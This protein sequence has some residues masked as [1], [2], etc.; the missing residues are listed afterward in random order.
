MVLSE[1]RD[2]IKV[3][4]KEAD[5]KTFVLSRGDNEC[6]GLSLKVLDAQFHPFAENCIVSCG[7]KHI[8]FWNLCGN[9]LT[10]KKGIFGKVRNSFT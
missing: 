9:A 10:D 2:T 6:H 4:W 1:N 8:K 7:A 5:R 3:T